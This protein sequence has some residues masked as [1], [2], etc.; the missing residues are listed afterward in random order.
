MFDERSHA[1]RAEAEQLEVHVALDGVPVVHISA[2]VL[3]K[4]EIYVRVDSHRAIQPGLSND[5]D[6]HV[7]AK[8]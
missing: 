2:H 5:W 8:G 6:S 3:A 7:A 4:V 1:C